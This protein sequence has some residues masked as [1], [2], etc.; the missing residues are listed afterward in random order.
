MT[1]KVGDILLIQDSKNIRKVAQTNSG[2]IIIPINT[3]DYGYARITKIVR[4]GLNYVLVE[5]EN[6][7]S[8]NI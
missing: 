8:K 7:I 4:K 3:I 1:C 2:K 6:I 5:M